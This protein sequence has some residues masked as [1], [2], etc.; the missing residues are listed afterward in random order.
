[1]KASEIVIVSD[2]RNRSPL[3]ATARGL[4]GK[5]CDKYVIGYWVPEKKR[6][7]FNWNDF[8]NVCESEG[9]QL[10]MVSEK[11]WKHLFHLVKFYL[12][13]SEGTSCEIGYIR[14]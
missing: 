3:S 12:S 10:K 2:T 6:Q 9:F 7:K 4:R 13:I 8:E 5:M 14:W 1:V 11:T